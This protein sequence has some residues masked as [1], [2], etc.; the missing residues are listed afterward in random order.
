MKSDLKVQIYATDLDKEAIDLARQGTYPA[1]IAQDVSE[2]R[3]KRFFIKKDDGRFQMK[4]EVREMVV[5][6]VQN[7][8]TDPPFTRLDL[9][10][11]T[12]LLIWLQQIPRRSSWHYS[13]SA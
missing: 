4:S 12:N 11:L 6:A 13:I 1:N 5:F 10:T 2:E 3:L 7:V 9:F 8:L